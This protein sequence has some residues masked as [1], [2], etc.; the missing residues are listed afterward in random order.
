MRA[1]VFTEPG[2]SS[3]SLSAAVCG[4]EALGRNLPNTG[5][6]QVETDR[7]DY[8]PTVR[9][10]PSVVDPDFINSAPQWADGAFNLFVTGRRLGNQALHGRGLH[11]RGL[12]IVSTYGLSGL[13][14]AAAFELAASTVHESGHAFGLV[15]PTSAR[16]NRAT[17]HCGN[18][19]VMQ[20]GSR[21][22]PHRLARIT[23][24]VAN[25]AL[26]GGFCG[27]CSADLQRISF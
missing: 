15:E 2:V 13:E 3:L 4:V 27:D 19:C 8:F 14:D 21:T 22:D 1:A 12:A 6:L 23:S 9:N 11:G 20:T 5:G 24:L 18:L 16:F 25:S 10:N 17:A 26:T 7:L